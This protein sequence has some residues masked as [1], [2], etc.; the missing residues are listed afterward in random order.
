MTIGDWWP[1]GFPTQQ[2]HLPAWLQTHHRSSL[3]F[4]AQPEALSLNLS[5]FLILLKG[6]D[7]PSVGDKELFTL[8]PD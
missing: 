2:W 6:T 4:R 3:N 7:V 8:I 1:Q 5:I